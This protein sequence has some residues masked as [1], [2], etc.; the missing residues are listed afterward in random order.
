MKEKKLS[1]WLPETICKLI[2]D[3]VL[4]GKKKR[5]SNVPLLHKYEHL[6]VTFFLYEI[7]CYLFLF[8]KLRQHL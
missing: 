6:G 7:H 3:S 5:N 8:G 4:D 1:Y 2:S